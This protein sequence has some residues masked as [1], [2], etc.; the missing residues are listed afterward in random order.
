MARW[1]R[2]WLVTIRLPIYRII[3]EL[4]LPQP[5]RVAEG[6]LR[7]TTREEIVAIRKQAWEDNCHANLRHNR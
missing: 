2:G 6:A 7:F 5:A 4:Q 1:E 3:D